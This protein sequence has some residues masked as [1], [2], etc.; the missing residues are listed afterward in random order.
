LDY[1]EK[2][3]ITDVIGER[4]FRDVFLAECGPERPQLLILDGHSS[5]ETLAIL[6]MALHEKIHVLS[7]PPHTTHLLHPLDR[8]VFGPLNAAYNRFCSE[9]LNEN[10]L[11]LVTKWSF[12]GLFAQAWEHELSP[13]NIQSG[14]R[15]CGIF[16]FNSAAIPKDSFA[17]SMPTD[18][19]LAT[20][21]PSVCEIQGPELAPQSS[22]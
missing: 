13:A 5:H 21:V 3:W 20:L 14:F 18:I 9:Y 8:T 22:S 16:P 4:W 12:P 17:P 10:P 11:N 6:E 15:A 1:R 19:P 2:G 7:L